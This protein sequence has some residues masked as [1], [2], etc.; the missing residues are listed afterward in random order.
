MEKRKGKIIAK[1]IAVV[2]FLLILYALMPYI[3]GIIENPPSLASYTIPSHAEFEFERNIYIEAVGT[4]TLNLTIPQNNTFQHVMIIDNSNLNKDITHV[5]NRTIWK[6]KLQNTTKLTIVYKGNLSAKVWNIDSSLDVDAIPLSLKKQY[7]HNES[8]RTYDE[9]NHTYV[10]KVVIQ[11]STFRHLTQKLTRNNTNVI[12]KLR[13]I[14]DII[15]SNFRY[16]SQRSGIP[17]SAAETWNS[18]E[19]DCDELSFVFVSM[20]R[21]IGIPARVEYGLVYTQ[22]NWGPHAWV[23][24]PIPTSKGLIWTN[25]DIT[26]EVG[27]ENI[28]RGFLIRDADRITEWIEDGNSQHLTEYYS[29]IK[30]YY[31]LKKPI[32]E[33]VK[34]IKMEK[35]GEISIPV[36]EAQI[37]QWVMML[38]IGL[39]IL[40]VFIVIIRY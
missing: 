24:T 31:D 21:S 16:K 38:I 39:I 6:Y 10:D 14:Y 22:N 29:F 33:N 17:N 20:A 37:P 7:N 15:I 1:V 19:G 34:I 35:S 2:I 27:G 25:I 12:E 40:A 13:T 26:L 3:T 9:Q 23:S 4:Y 8:I 30:G 32:H 18:K 11:P 36:K 5:S 28:G